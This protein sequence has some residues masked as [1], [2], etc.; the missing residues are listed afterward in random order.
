MKT[1]IDKSKVMK[2]AWSIFRLNMSMYRTF[3]ECLKRA[4]EIEKKNI[5]YRAEQEAIAAAEIQRLCRQAELHEKMKWQPVDP[6][7]GIREYLMNYYG[8]PFN[9]RG[10]RRYFGD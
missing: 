4:W 6:Y 3:A 8:N 9:E 10:Q 2:R 5:I 1:T 7:A